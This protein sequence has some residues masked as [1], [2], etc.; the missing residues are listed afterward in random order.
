MAQGF[1]SALLQ[2]LPVLM[3]Q[4]YPGFKISPSG[5][6]KSLI[7]NAPQ[8]Q[9]SGV[10][11]ERITPLSLS[12]DGVGQIHDVTV[13]FLPRLRPASVGTEDD[14]TTDNILTYLEQSITAPRTAQQTLFIDWNTVRRYEAAAVELLSL[15]TTPN[16]GVIR[17]VNTQIMHAVNSIINHIDNNLLT[18]VTWGAN[19]V[20]QNQLAKTININK[21]GNVFD[22]TNGMIEIMND[23]QLNEFTGTPVIVG[24]GL[25]NNFVLS[26]P[27]VGI[28]GGGLNIAAFNDYKWYLDV[29]ATSNANWGANRVGVFAPGSI[30]FVDIDEYVGFQAGRF[31]TSEFATIMLPVGNDT[32]TTFRFGIQIRE[33]DC[34]STHIRNYSAENTGRGY[35]IYIRKRYG[36]W[37]QP[38]DAYDD[39]DRLNN[40]NGALRYVL[41]N[42]CDSCPAAD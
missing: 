19:T 42:D 2:S 41:S 29:N 36:L 26:R 15:G 21:D 33:V 1:A 32:S 4:N 28:N 11:G 20:T 12:T 14:C 27:G 7:E 39:G 40:V 17:E 22:L 23:Y 6:F 30:G 37:Q 5:L 3:G 10:N 25:F 9:V 35:E 18:D 38:I 16:I 34:P 31:G 8:L 13:K 24:S